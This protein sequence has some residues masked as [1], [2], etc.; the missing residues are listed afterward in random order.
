MSRPMT[1]PVSVL[2][3]LAAA[4]A[5]ATMVRAGHE[6]P[7]YPSYY[8]HE[9]AIETMPPER[10]ARLLLESKIQAYVGPEPRF[11]GELPTSIRA[12]ESLGSFIIVLLN[13]ALP[14]PTYAASTCGAVETIVRDMAGK[15][16]FVF[17]PYPVTPFHGDYLHYADLAEATKTRFLRPA[18][19]TSSAPLVNLRV[20]V[21][22]ALKN[23]VRVRHGMSRSRRS[24]RRSSS[25][26][27]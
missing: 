24:T 8:P 5:I 15:P 12:V 22:S 10:A 25:P 9:I 1:K 27:R 7:V 20:K 3:A 14:A 26:R 11:A 6:L 17:H 19:E 23:L 18:A 16:G 13:P 2:I 21:G 4:L